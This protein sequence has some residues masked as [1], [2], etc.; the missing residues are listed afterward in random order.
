M[1]V[2]AGHQR[3]LTLIEEFAKKSS[4]RQGI[5][6]HQVSIFVLKLLPY[7]CQRFT[8]RLPMEVLCRCPV[9]SSHWF[10]SQPVTSQS[11]GPDCDLTIEW[12]DLASGDVI[13][14]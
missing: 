3:S 7:L 8:G 12:L 1:E 10:H 5:L 6:L 14:S 4:I 9:I 11:T 2:S 13:H